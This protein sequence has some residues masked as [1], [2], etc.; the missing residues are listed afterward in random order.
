MKRR[1]FSLS[2]TSPP[3]PQRARK[4]GAMNYGW[5][6]MAGDSIPSMFSHKSSS[7]NKPPPTPP[8]ALRD[9]VFCFCE[10]SAKEPIFLWSMQHFGDFSGMAERTFIPL[11]SLVLHPSAGNGPLS[12]PAIGN[13]NQKG[14]TFLGE[15]GKPNVVQDVTL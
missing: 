13:Q 3:P 10:T 11:P 4:E 2:A 5:A 12:G 7:I 6:V 8:L 14:W 9:R 1:N 15:N